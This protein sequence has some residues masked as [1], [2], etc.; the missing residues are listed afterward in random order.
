MVGETYF[1]IFQD[2][3]FSW[4]KRQLI[5]KRPA[6]TSRDVLHTRDIWYIMAHS[7]KSEYT[8][9]GECAPIKGLSIDP[10][11]QIEKVLEG[12]CAQKFNPS[13]LSQILID[14]PA[15]NFALETLMA[16]LENG[17]DRLLFGQYPIEIPINGLVWMNE[18]QTML[19]EALEKIEAGYSCIKLKIGSLN[20]SD[21]LEILQQIRER[22]TADELVIRLDANGA[23]APEEVAG[24]LE[25][26]ARFAIHSIE[27]PVRP[28][29]FEVMREL[30]RAQIIPIALDEEL[31]GVKESVQREILI[32]KI[33]PDYLILKPGIHGG[34][35]AS[36]E[37]ISL[38]VRYGGNWWVTSALESNVG[39]NAIAQ[40]V[41]QFD[42][43]L[44]QGLGTGML[45]SNNIESPIQI[46]QGCL[47][48]KD[49]FG[50][51]LSPI[52]ENK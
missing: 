50:W 44:P 37:W 22:Y 46:G 40:W 29:Q 6:R 8:A 28:G 23:F 32:E 16:D 26:L 9:I 13:E 1:R 52:L 31:I 17:N 11:D 4:T 51:N 38:I 36:E 47:K 10:S 48:I 35:S 30:V 42:P 18:K 19:T 20:F 7:E 21:E 12:I 15:V 3:K 41:G 34:F 2:V 27:Q 43:Q 45:F 24:K 5:F 14:F 39:L 49:S 25:K 33:Q